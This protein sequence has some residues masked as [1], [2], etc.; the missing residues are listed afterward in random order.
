MLQFAVI[1]LPFVHNGLN[2][3][4]FHEFLRQPVQAVASG[5]FQPRWRIFV[6]MFAQPNFG[7]VFQIITAC[8]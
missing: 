8:G 1:H 7:C 3:S 4:V 6:Q 5:F 2:G